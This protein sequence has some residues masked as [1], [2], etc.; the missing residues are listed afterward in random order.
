MSDRVYLD[1]EPIIG[2]LLASIDDAIAE[3]AL[4]GARLV[5][6][7]AATHH[8][9]RNRTGTLQSRTQAGRVTGR[10]S[11]GIVRVDVLGDTRYGSFVEQGTSRSRPYPYL[12]PAWARREEDFARAVDEA[13]ERGVT[14]VL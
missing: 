12:A 14:R 1:V 5:A 8:P 9:Y 4:A 2:A 7:E 6:E 13:L 11:R 10:A 3:G